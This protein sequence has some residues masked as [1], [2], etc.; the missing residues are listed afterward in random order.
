MKLNKLIVSAAAL[1]VVST[2]LFA[3]TS[4]MDVEK[5]FERE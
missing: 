4:N 1:A 3:G 2:G 5:V